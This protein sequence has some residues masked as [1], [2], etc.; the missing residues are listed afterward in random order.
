M[1]AAVAGCSHEADGREP[2]ASLEQQRC[3]DADR[4]F[5]SPV[6][7]CNYGEFGTGWNDRMWLDCGLLRCGERDGHGGCSVCGGCGGCSGCVP[8]SPQAQAT[9]KRQSGNTGQVQPA[10]LSPVM[11]HTS[12]TAL[13]LL[14]RSFAVDN[15]TEPQIPKSLTFA[16][17][18][19]DASDVLE[20]ESC[21][22]WLLSLVGWPAPTKSAV[23][24]WQSALGHWLSR[25]RR[26]KTSTSSI[27]SCANAG[28]QGES[29]P[30][31]RTAS[32]RWQVL[33]VLV[34]EQ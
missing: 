30:D 5:C 24:W 11:L 13:T 1:A 12:R 15:V 21:L 10:K 14:A 19:I 22:A 8:S 28:C 6:W 9:R 25:L 18:A 17:P 34:E 3:I 27:A 4:G 20:E 33:G 16:I 29:G 32:E 23:M 26:R 7:A 2:R 31:W